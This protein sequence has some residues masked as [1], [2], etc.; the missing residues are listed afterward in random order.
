MLD[1]DAGLLGVADGRLP[2]V[3]L[4]RADMRDFELDRRFDVVTCLFSSIGY[5]RT[6]DH[7]QEAIATMARHVAPGGILA[8]EPWL[9]PDAFES[10]HIGRGILVERPNMQAVRMNGSRVE[11][12]QSILDFHYL[13][14]TPG[15]VEHLSETHV[16]GLFTHDEYALAFKLAGLVADHDAEGLMGRGLWIG[17]RRG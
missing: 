4:H 13:V 1:T 16:L 9:A 7:L 11:G 10:R 6:V 14:A 5:M 3:P 12:T 17:S 15:R 2:G 8:V